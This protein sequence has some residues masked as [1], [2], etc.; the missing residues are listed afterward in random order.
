MS[1]SGKADDWI[2][3]FADGE[4]DCAHHHTVLNSL[5]DPK[6]LVVW[7][8]Y[9][10]IGDVLRSPTL[11]SRMDVSFAA[12]LTARLADEPIHLKPIACAASHC[13]TPPSL[14][15]SVP[16]G[17]SFGWLRR[18]GFCGVAVA[19]LATIALTVQ[20]SSLGK[21]EVSTLPASHA[22]ATTRIAPQAATQTT[23][24][25]VKTM[26]PT[27]LDTQIGDYLLAHQRLSPSL[28]RSDTYARLSNATNE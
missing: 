28:Y 5:R 22:M 20:L 6:A 19:V 24:D 2:S 13:V 16:D 11:A 10:S 1:N 7:D 4:L 8:C 14:S 17:G 21:P 23:K 26:E 12:R 3:A 15:F 27:M 25:V 9:H 18:L